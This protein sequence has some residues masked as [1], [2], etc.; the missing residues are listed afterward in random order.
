MKR[1]S[2]SSP[3]CPQPKQQ[4]LDESHTPLT[5]EV[6]KEFDRHIPGLSPLS[7]LPMSGEAPK[8]SD[9]PIMPPPSN[10]S[11]QRS[12]STSPSKPSEAQYRGANIRRANICIDDEIPVDINDYVNRTV[13]QDLKG[14]D[15]SVVS[16]RLCNKSKELVTQSAGELEWTEALYFAIGEIMSEELRIVQNRGKRHLNSVIRVDA[17]FCKIGVRILSLP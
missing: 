1:S 3:S 15:L 2:A 6:L 7:F 12:R 4:K 14:Y 11:S 5:H 13:F 9:I 17:N 16:E 10:P 8:F